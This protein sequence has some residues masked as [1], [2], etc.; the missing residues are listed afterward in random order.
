MKVENT[1]LLKKKRK[2]S[3]MTIK[4][5]EVNNS[6]SDYKIRTISKKSEIDSTNWAT[7]S[8]KISVN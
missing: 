1:L 2:M 4:Y 8:P 6:E 3:E 5:D 7:Q